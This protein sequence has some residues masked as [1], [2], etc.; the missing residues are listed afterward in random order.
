[1]A[2]A[3]PGHIAAHEHLPFDPR[4]P[5]TVSVRDDLIKL[6]TSIKSAAAA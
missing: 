1:M 5:V 4:S 3:A 2:A 6:A